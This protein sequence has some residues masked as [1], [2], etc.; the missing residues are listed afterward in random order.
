[1]KATKGSR[2]SVRAAVYM[3]A[4][5][6][7]LVTEIIEIAVDAT[8]ENKM[9]RITPR[10]IMLAIKHDDDFPRLLSHVIMPSTGSFPNIHKAL[11][12][13]SKKTKSRTQNKPSQDY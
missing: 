8:K 7:Y 9:Q 10:F 3:T 12:P 2:I 6:E 11:L 5:L 4:V 13:K 1:M